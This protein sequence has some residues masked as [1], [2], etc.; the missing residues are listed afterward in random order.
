VARTVIDVDELM[1][2][3]LVAPPEDDTTERILDAA[4]E[5]FVTRGIRRCS[6]EEI[7]ERSGVGR[8]TVYRRFE[9]RNQIVQAV[10]ARETQRFFAGILTATAG[11][12]LFEDLV[13]EAF[14]CG[15]DAAQSS[16]LTEMVRTQPELRSLFTV[17]AEPLIGAATGFLVMAFGPVPSDDER[18]RVAAVAELLVRLAISL[19]VSGPGGLPVGDDDASRRALHQLLD[20]LLVPLAG[21][22]G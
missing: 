16:L 15:L 9:H 19:V 8:T 1:R 10:L 13:V 6:V 4:A 14:L 12:E 7:A 22:R 5:L 18:A 2:S 3:A 20:P 17:D 11:I 21:L